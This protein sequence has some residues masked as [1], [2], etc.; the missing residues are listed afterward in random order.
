[1]SREITHCPCKGEKFEFMFAT[2]ARGVAGQPPILGYFL[3]CPA[4]GLIR[5]REDQCLPDEAYHDGTYRE[6]IKDS[7]GADWWNAAE[8][9]SAAFAELM[10]LPVGDSVA[11]IGAGYGFFLKALE[12]RRRLAIEPNEACLKHMAVHVP[13][14]ITPLDFHALAA[15][16]DEWPEPFDHVTS[17][18][19]LEHV[20]D[21]W[22][23]LRRARRLMH[24]ETQLHVV[25]PSLDLERAFLDAR[26]RQVWFCA[27]HRWYYTPAA[28]AQVFR[29]CGFTP[30]QGLGWERRD[31]W[32]YT[33]LH[34]TVDPDWREP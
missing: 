20:E 1:M 14:E 22:A 21:P 31:G 26:Y 7:I 2:N 34:G 16:P 11:D 27:Q 32:K 23:I 24:T 19:V 10:N 18:L 8:E 9:Q 25:V 13:P 15:I 17:I 29:D 3:Q 28:L 30:G 33:Y 4:C 5:L 12:G 6:S